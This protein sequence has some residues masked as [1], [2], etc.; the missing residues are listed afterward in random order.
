VRR[1]MQENL[2]E[3]EHGLKQW[4]DKVPDGVL[5][6]VAHCFS[7]CL[8]SGFPASAHF[9]LLPAIHVRDCF[10]G[11]LGWQLARFQAGRCTFLAVA[12]HLPE[13]PDLCW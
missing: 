4:S 6:L 11:F 8:I 10:A 3:I 7:S 12:A 5:Q 13:R 1:F 9:M 2:R